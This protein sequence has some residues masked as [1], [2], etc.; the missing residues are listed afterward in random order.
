MMGKLV[1]LA[2]PIDGHTY[3]SCTNW[4]EYAI[5]ELAVNKITGI[6]PMRAKDFLKH[7]PEIIDGVSQHVLASDAGIT[8]RDMWDVRRSDAVLFNLLEAKKVSI[9][10]MI[11]YGWASSFD[12]PIITLME[13]QGNIHEHAMVR[14]LSD[15]RVENLEEGLAVV[16]ALFDY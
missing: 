12:K 16:R 3:D 5:K 1:Y 14:R 8:A 4:R 10:T 13:K 7:H 15:Y 2:G 9:G 11:E 6:S